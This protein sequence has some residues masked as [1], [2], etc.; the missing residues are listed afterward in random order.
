MSDQPR[1]GL[2]SDRPLMTLRVSRD[3]GR[4]WESERAVFAGDGSRLS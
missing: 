2:F 4:T 3:A 1:S